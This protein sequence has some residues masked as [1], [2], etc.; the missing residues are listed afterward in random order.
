MKGLAERVV[1][2]G[3]LATTVCG[4]GCGNKGAG[5]AAPAY[6]LRVSWPLATGKRYSLHRVWEAAPRKSGNGNQIHDFE[7]LVDASS[8][9]TS[10]FEVSMQ[11][12]KFHGVDL[13]KSETGHLRQIAPEVNKIRLIQRVGALGGGQGWHSPGYTNSGWAGMMVNKA[14]G[15]CE[16]G[17]M[18]LSFPM[19]P[20][21]V[22]GGWESRIHVG[23]EALDGGFV[24]NVSGQNPSCQFRL[25][26]VDAA[27]NTARISF[28]YA[29]R[30]TANYEDPFDHKLKSLA[31]PDQG[32]GY[33]TIDLGSGLPKTFHADRR[34]SQNNQGAIESEHTV[35]DV[36]EGGVAQK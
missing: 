36:T 11:V 32:S 12:Q 29:T 20:V 5:V 18:D 1:V 27:H 13:D 23:D 10:A 8:T 4:C 22:G 26:D 24:T 9:G 33:W 21:P 2:I 35:T 31:H 34:T 30:I 3:V 16:V 7:V 25:E 14:L 19:K 6:N 15:F 17:F 28:S